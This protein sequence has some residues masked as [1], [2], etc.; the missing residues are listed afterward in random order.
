MAKILK[1][2]QVMFIFLSLFLVVTDASTSSFL[3]KENTFVIECYTN[4]DCVHRVCK[5][6]AAPKCL[7]CLRCICL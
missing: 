7:N 2:V 3:I 4:T 1:Y 6:P 5:P